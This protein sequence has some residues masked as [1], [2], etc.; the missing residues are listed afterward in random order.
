MVYKKDLAKNEERKMMLISSLV[1]VLLFGTVTYFSDS[2]K[3][4][5][6]VMGFGGMYGAIVASQ[7]L[8]KQL[9][10][11]VTIAFLALVQILLIIS[12]KWNICRS[13]HA[14]GFAIIVFID[15]ILV[16]G[17]IKLIERLMKKQDR[18]SSQK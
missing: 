9:W 15:A 17:I 5:A 16:Y 3:G 13:F 12:F 2:N 7:Q 18:A 14:P 11:R 6:A 10:Y 1:G 4:V 8:W